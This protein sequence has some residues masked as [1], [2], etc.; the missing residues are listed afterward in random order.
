VDR[1][2]ERHTDSEMNRE[3][4]TETETDIQTDG[5]EWT[6]TERKK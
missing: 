6:D 1:G 2:L 4:D 5:A 3:R